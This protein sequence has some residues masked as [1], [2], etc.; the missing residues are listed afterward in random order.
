MSKT[1]KIVLLVAAA[2][3]AMACLACT[4]TAFVLFR[5][6]PAVV[7]APGYEMRWPTRPGPAASPLKSYQMF[8]EMRPCEYAL[9][10]W[11]AGGALYYQEACR[12]GEPRIWAAD[13]EARGR[14]SQ[15]TA[16]PAGLL[17][18]TVPRR[19]ILEWARSPMVYPAD[20]EPDVRAL[21]VRV[22]GIASPDGRWVAVVV[23]HIYGPEDVIV[24]STSK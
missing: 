22:D 11:S 20:A 19:S 21:E 1:G 3:A 2:V 17:Q 9:L 14:P 16:P 18:E 15:V 8:F 4:V 24:L 7:A 12:E 5:Y 6:Q 10:G 13:P 23:R